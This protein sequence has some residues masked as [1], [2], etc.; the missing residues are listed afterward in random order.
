[1]LFREHREL[2]EVCGFF[3]VFGFGEIRDEDNAMRGEDL[4]GI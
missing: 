2:R 1:M 3:A 4:Q